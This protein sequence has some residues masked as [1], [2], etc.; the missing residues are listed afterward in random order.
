[1]DALTQVIAERQGWFSRADALKVGL[2]DQDLTAGVRRRQLLRL[3]HGVYTLA[4]PHMMRSETQR[5]L[6]LARA[7]VATQR[8]Q[9]ALTATSAA[10]V[11]GLSVWGHDLGVVHLLRL[12]D[13]S[14]RTQA[15][16]HHHVVDGDI[17]SDVEQRVGLPVT[18][19]PRTVWEV[20]R[21]TSLECAVSTTDSA[22]ARDPD[23]AETLAM[24]QGRFR[25][26]PGSRTARLALRLADAG[27]QSPGESIT[28]VQC[29]RSAIPCPELQFP[30][31]DRSGRL[32]GV[33]D[34][35]WPEFRH[36]AEFDG[37]VKYEQYLRPGERPS[38]AVFR[39]KQRED[40][41]RAQGWGMTRITWSDIM[42]ER[43]RVTMHRLR[44]DLERSR[45][46]YVR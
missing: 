45:T 35:A 19:L 31:H 42:A 14:P 10:V 12:D 39:E 24:M 21:T 13:G 1:M 7:V 18:T 5:H 46:L 3:R 25:H 26:H 41:M 16:C 6:L 33:S 34:F 15:G 37:R 43:A 20:A 36:L 2:T 29:Y 30:V 22:L 9:V 38:D 17:S 23:L 27:A 8:G 11:H 4:E 32:L 44:Q 40:A 28:R